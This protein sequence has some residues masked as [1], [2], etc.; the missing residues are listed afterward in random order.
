M[1]TV[2]PEEFNNGSRNTGSKYAASGGIPNGSSANRS[3]ASNLIV[4]AENVIQSMDMKFVSQEQIDQWSSIYDSLQKYNSV[5]FK[6]HQAVV[7]T[8][9]ILD[10]SGLITLPNNHLFYDLDDASIIVFVNGEYLAPTKYNIV[11]KR[12]F[13]ISTE[14]IKLN[15]IIN[16]I[17]MSKES[18]ASN[19]DTRLMALAVAWSYSYVNDTGGPLDTIVLDSEYSFVSEEEYSLLV[20][21]DGL[22]VH[23]RNFDIIGTH[24][25]VFKNGMTLP[26][27]SKIEILQLARV[28][29]NEEYIGFMWGETIDVTASGTTFELSEDHSFENVQDNSLL[30]YIDGRTTRKYN[31]VNTNTI[32]FE[33]IIPAGSV[34]DI[35]QL[36]FTADINKL[37]EILDRSN[38]DEIIN[39]DIHDYVNKSLGDVPG[40]YA[41]INANG[42]ISQS[43]IDI[44]QLSDAIAEKLDEKEWVPAATKSFLHTHSN[45][46]DL[47]RLSV[48]E[49]VLYLDDSPVG[50]MAEETY[51]NIDLTSANIE[52]CNIELPYDCDTDMPIVVSISGITLVRGVDYEIVQNTWPEKDLISWNGYPLQDTVITGDRVAITYYKKKY[53]NE[54]DTNAE[55]QTGTITNPDPIIEEDGF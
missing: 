5:S 39:F 28:F 46:E 53:V 42:Y 49:D 15:D 22:Y 12:Q 36:G 54:E 50:E 23:P 4:Y 29:P 47:E 17:H 38:I 10:N 21:I 31:I 1:A 44:D 30:V 41:K 32:E 20:F 26:N 37:K 40:G 24:T 52:N 25:L 45:L 13:Y 33:E 6:W 9:D 3:N 35:V 51:Y 7:I 14:Y 2:Y 55:T 11:N 27:N 16:I 48:R 43:V 8:Q 34:I 19:Y 18:G